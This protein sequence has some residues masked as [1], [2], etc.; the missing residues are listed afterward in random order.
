MDIADLE[1]R[2]DE[3]RHRRLAAEERAARLT[4]AIAQMRTIL[5][6]EDRS[7]WYT[8]VAGKGRGPAP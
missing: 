5:R 4:E 8:V 6:A 2:L 3:E 1:R 7:S